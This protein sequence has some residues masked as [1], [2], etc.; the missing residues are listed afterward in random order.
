MVEE[1]YSFMIPVDYIVSANY[2]LS[3]RTKA[4]GPCLS[5]E[6]RK[7]RRDI[8]NYLRKVYNEGYLDPLKGKN[9]QVTIF[10]FLK[11]SFASRDLDNLEKLSIDGIFKFF[12]LNDNRI[13]NKTTAKRHVLGSDME[14]IYVKISE[15]PSDKKLNYDLDEI[16]VLSKGGE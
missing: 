10:Y 3:Y 2:R 15:I 1:A 13:I 12:N 6:A 9:L 7:E 8:S 14:Y 4:K 11:K 5:D 16:R